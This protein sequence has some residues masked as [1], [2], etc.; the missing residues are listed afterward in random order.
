MKCSE[1]QTQLERRESHSSGSRPFFPGSITPTYPRPPGHLPQATRPPTEAS[2]KVD[3]WR[4]CLSGV[5]LATRA[6]WNQ[7]SCTMASSSNPELVSGQQR[8]W[9]LAWRSQVAQSPACHSQMMTH[10]LNP[11]QGEGQASLA[12][13]VALT[14]SED[15]HLPVSPGHWPEGKSNLLAGPRGASGTIVI[16]LKAE[17]ES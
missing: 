2:W 3:G 8:D 1:F 16:S 7:Q 9:I 4:R 10:S 17:Q 11:L 14:G 6:A 12:G 13:G 15:F 5:F